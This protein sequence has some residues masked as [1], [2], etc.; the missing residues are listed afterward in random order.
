MG[1]ARANTAEDWAF[2]TL[3]K[4][5]KYQEIVEW[6]RQTVSGERARVSRLFDAEL[7]PARSVIT[8]ILSEGEGTVGEGICDVRDVFLSS[9]LYQR[10]VRLLEV[11]LIRLR[12]HS[13]YALFSA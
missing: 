5:S 2:Q 1:E 8:A 13:L 12:C 6:L 3:Q 4:R 9:R 10:L 11:F 7:V